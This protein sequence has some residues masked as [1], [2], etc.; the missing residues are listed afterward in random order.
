MPVYK[1]LVRLVF[2][3]CVCG[4]ICL[5][6]FSSASAMTPDVQQLMVSFPF[7]DGFE[8]GSFGSGWTPGSA[9]NGVAQIRTDDPH[10]GTYHAFLGQHQ[11][12]N[13][14]A[15]LTLLVDLAN[16]A[17][18]YM[19]FW[20]RTT[21]NDFHHGT[22]DSGIYISDDNGVNWKKIKDF[23]GNNSHYSHDII[24]LTA[25]AASQGL[26]LNNH[27]LIRFYYEREYPLVR[28][29]GIRLDDLRLTTASEVTAA[30]PLQ[31]GFEPST[32]AKGFYSSNLGYGVA[33]LSNDDPH[34]GER[35]I[36][37]GQHQAGNAYASLNLLVNLAN[38][39]DV[40]LD[41]WWR[42]TGNDFHHGTQDSG[43]YI[44][45]D[46]GSNWKKIKD[47]RD[48]SNYSHDV[49]NLTA[50]ASSRG[51]NLNNHFLIGFYYEREYPLERLGGIRLD[52]IRLTTSTQVTATFPLQNGFESPT[53]AKGFYPSNVGQGIT[54]ISSDFPHRGASHVFI[55][56]NQSGSAYASLILLADLANQPAV[57]LDFWWHTTGNNFHH[58]TQDSGVYISDDDGN[59]WRKIRDFRETPQYKHEI[60]NL[61]EAAANQGLTLNKHFRVYFYYEREYSLP[62]L[63]GIRIDDIRLGRSYPANRVYL[64][65]IEK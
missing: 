32:L 44:S 1:S 17:S 40:Y 55:G 18:V 46:N 54:E 50:A 42:T 49:I 21:G 24:N 9:A 19:D 8:S 10:S 20:W 11:S 61:A 5:V 58:G 34:T 37:L 2:M 31:N 14:Y 63:G 60:I 7:S 56:Q 28:L 41:F 48:N 47:F 51:L 26:N 65:F 29:G 27:F 13:A 6:L 57:Y 45:D 4:G 3:L 43:I 36:F 64:P 35:H 30:F 16:Q 53:F 39:P 15:S 12:G 62:R 23:Q 33:Q 25:V 22:Q 38:Q 59:S 52:D